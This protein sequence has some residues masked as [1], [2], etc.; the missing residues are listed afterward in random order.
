MESSLDKLVRVFNRALVL[1]SASSSSDSENVRIHHL[2]NFKHNLGHELLS[3]VSV[4]D[5]WK[6]NQ[7][8]V[9]LNLQHSPP[10]S[11]GGQ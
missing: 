9:F 4:E 2:E 5:L 3:I 8:K 11:L 7:S 6:A 10:S 1:W